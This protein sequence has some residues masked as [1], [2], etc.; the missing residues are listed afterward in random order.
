MAQRPITYASEYPNPNDPILYPRLTEAQLATIAEY[1]TCRE[2]QAGEL[3]FDQ[4]VRN[5]PFYILER[6]ALEFFD[7]QPESD[8]YFAR[9]PEGT[10]AGD[11]AMFTGEP[12]VAACIAVEPSRVLVMER[13]RLRQ[14]VAE[15]S[16][17]G[18]VILRTFLARRA[19]LEG[20]G[21]GQVSILGTRW[22]REAHRLREFLG[23]N[24]I[25]HRWLDLDTDASARKLVEQLEIDAQGR[26]ILIVGGDVCRDPTLEELAEY[27]GLS[28]DPEDETYD[29]VVVGGGPAGLAAA[30]YGAS[31]GLTTFVVEGDSPGG[32]AG[33]SSKI[34]NYL[35]F[36]TGI[37]G[38][39]LTR[40]AVLQARKFG[41]T[42]SNPRS[43][44][45]IDCSGT[46]KDLELDN[47]R[48]VYARCVVIATGAEYRRLSCAGCEEYEGRGVYYAASHVEASACADEEVVIVGGGNSAGQAAVFL[49]GHA[50]KV[51]V[52][53]R[54]AGLAETMSKYLIDRIERTGNIEVVT[55]AE[56]AAVR[57][58][59]RLESLDLRLGDGQT[60]RIDAGGLFVMIGAVPRTSWLRDCVLM[61]DAGFVLTG[62]ELRRHPDFATA[63]RLERDPYLLETSVPGMFAAGDARCGSVKRVASAVGEGSMSVAFVHKVLA[64]QPVEAAE[65]T[66][67]VA[68]A[69]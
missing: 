52:V 37:S 27:L 45:H 1:A 58:D 22:S 20:H 7:S 53:V 47:G 56:V 10:F 21:L 44:R 6:G 25:P 66:A 54:R 57:G 19:W 16:E 49:S 50:K 24:Q 68:G 38:G 13:D 61:D 41:A 67:A 64:E 28:V 23:R 15:H 31:E 12:T 39:E 59:G 14:L 5:A 60:R 26:P 55:Q 11:I 48:H 18:D 30:V 33:T 36:L 43:V 29:L 46:H 51:Y 17:I 35:G 8:H 62:D 9:L 40:Q 65:P 34:E 63:W 32:Q 69:R 2:F 4:A 3:L 42:I